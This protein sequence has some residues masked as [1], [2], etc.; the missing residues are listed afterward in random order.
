MEKVNEEKLPGLM[1]SFVSGARK[2]TQMLI[3]SIIPNVVF[4]FTITRILAL[5]GILG[6]LGQLLSPVMMIF[7]LP[8]EAAM[9]LVLSISALAAGVSSAASLLASGIINGSQAIMMLPFIFLTGGLFV[10]TGRILSVTGIK[11]KYYKI[12]YAIALI[13]GVISLFV[14][15]LLMNFIG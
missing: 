11:T 1:T 7:G 12:F 13:N 5:T 4:S 15:K 2:G 6:L 9:P 3:N 10:Y 14:M 8:G